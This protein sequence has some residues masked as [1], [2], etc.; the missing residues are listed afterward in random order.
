VVDEALLVRK[1]SL[2]R[3]GV[4]DCR[5]WRLDDARQFEHCI[6]SEVVLCDYTYEV[7]VFPA[8]NPSLFN[9]SHASASL[10][11]VRP[12][13]LPSFNGCAIHPHEDQSA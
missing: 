13:D 7:D 11:S 8:H 12:A 5:F 3:G 9:A 6:S 4:L 1:R 2:A 10:T